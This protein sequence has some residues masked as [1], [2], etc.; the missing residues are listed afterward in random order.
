MASADLQQFKLVL[1]WLYMII[2]RSRGAIIYAQY[3]EMRLKYAGRSHAYTLQAS[4]RG[5]L[6]QKGRESSCV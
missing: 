6:G 5:D 4:Q 2:R 1:A 3:S